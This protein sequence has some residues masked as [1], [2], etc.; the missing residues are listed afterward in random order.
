M[1]DLVLTLS[2]DDPRLYTLERVGTLRLTFASRGA[3]AET[4][5]DSWRIAHRRWW[6]GAMDATDAAGTAVGSFEPRTPRRGG[7]VRWDARELTLLPPKLGRERYVLASGD[8]ELAI[9]DGGGRNPRPVTVTV[10]D[11]GAI[12]PGLLLFAAFLVRGFAAAAEAAR[13]E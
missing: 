1:V 8:R 6:R 13:G 12:E 4:G 3:T 10:E 5:V 2:P 11:P 9:L 7:A